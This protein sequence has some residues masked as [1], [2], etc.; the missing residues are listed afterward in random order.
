[1]RTIIIITLSLVAYE[2]VAQIVINAPYF[3]WPSSIDPWARDECLWIAGYQDD[4]A[5]D[6]LFREGPAQAGEEN[7]MFPTYG[8][9]EEQVFQRCFQS[10]R[11]W[12]LGLRPS[13]TRVTSSELHGLASSEKQSAPVAPR[14]RRLPSLQSE[15]GEIR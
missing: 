15:R 5:E 9:W 1:M 3:N 4:P 6:R 14:A 10:Q 7:P 2:G 11:R 8:P 13:L 12:R